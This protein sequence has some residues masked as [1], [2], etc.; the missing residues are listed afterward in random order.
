MPDKPTNLRERMFDF[1]CNVVLFC[2][3]L[4]SEPG[5]VRQ[6]AWQLADAA[7]SAGSN[8][9]EAKAAY[10]RREFAVKNCIALKE[11]REA[12]LW[13]RIIKACDLA[14][15]TENE[16]LLQEAG[17]LVGILTAT[18]RTARQPQSM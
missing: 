2:R 9:E 17:E 11:A 18:V 4:S 8:L 14:P 13:L 1:V 15:A 10:S 3:A 16:P 5:V 12:R 7:T 6:I